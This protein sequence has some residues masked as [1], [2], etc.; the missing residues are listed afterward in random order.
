MLQGGIRMAILG[1]NACIEINNN[2]F[3]QAGIKQLY[4][5]LA[6]AMA[7]NKEDEIT[8][9][10]KSCYAG[11][12]SALYKAY[13][14]KILAKKGYESNNSLQNGHRSI[15]SSDKFIDNMIQVAK[16]SSSI[17]SSDAKHN[18]IK[19]NIT[20]YFLNNYL[21]P[22]DE[23]AGN[24]YETSPSSGASTDIT[25]ANSDPDESIGTE[26]N[27]KIESED[28]SDFL[29][30]EEYELYG[31]DDYRQ[32]KQSSYVVEDQK[33]SKIQTLRSVF[34]M[35]Y[36]FLPD[37][38]RRLFT[39]NSDG[40]TNVSNLD[41]DAYMGRKYIER[42]AQRGNILFL[43]PGSV[44][45][46]KG[47]SSKTKQRVVEG[48][49]SNLDNTAS[50]SGLLNDTESYRYYSFDFDISG[51]F[52]YLNPMLRAAARYL[53]LQNYT[54]DGEVVSEAEFLKHTST[55]THANYKDIIANGAGTASMFNNAYGALTF[56]LD[57]VNNTSDSI[58]TS[59]GNSTFVDSYIKPV[60]STAQELKFLAGKGITDLTNADWANN[61]VDENSIRNSMQ[62][63]ENFVNKYL[64]SNSLAKKLSLG[65]VTVGSGGQ[66]IF[67][68]IWND[69]TF[70]TD[71]VN[72]DIK[73]TSPDCDDLSLFWNILTPM[74]AVLCMAAPKG[75]VGIDGYSQPFL[76]RAF[77]QSMFNIEAGYITG[78]TIRKGAEGCWTKSGLPTVLE[79]S[80]T[81]TDV[82]ESKYI[83]TG[84]K[85]NLLSWNPIQTVNNV[86][87]KTPFLKNTAMLNWIA[88]TCGVNVNKPDMIRDIEMY[89]EHSIENPVYDIFTNFTLSAVDWLRNLAPVTL[90]IIGQI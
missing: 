1:K 55:L 53:K 7:L 2:V 82:Y 14:A 64:G 37:T 46:L 83:S 47:A 36:Q 3:A 24:L 48:F 11:I 78:L 84:E 12:T 8:A 21:I 35:P 80:L 71:S 72:L 81:I 45:F 59:L 30:D 29:T 28:E 38:D 15:I 54:V 77:C 87:Q 43:T 60:S 49:L 32:D 27:S 68:K 88:C 31:Y 18:N 89:I 62:E 90:N 13:A 4:E 34:G 50:M 86:V 40:S 63:I 70:E 20:N 33:Y 75:Y 19:S 79:I 65:A 17:P 85:G 61:V 69:T 26:V 74:Y 56:Y 22:L 5:Q 73:L 6:N 39:D 52:E 51:F 41:K 16:N 67:P 57:G 10:C 9:V 42:I 58:N 25:N 66:I 23:Y 76:V 44:R